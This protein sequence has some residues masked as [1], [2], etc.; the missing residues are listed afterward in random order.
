ME[1]SKSSKRHHYLPRCYLRGFTNS[2]G[3]FYVYD[4]H[5]DKIFLTS[6]DASFFENNLNTI[7]SSGD[8]SKDFLEGLYRD[9]ENEL[10]PAIAYIIKAD[11]AKDVIGLGIREQIFLFLLF[12]HW[13][14][15]SNIAYVQ[16][17]ASNS[18]NENGELNYFTLTDKQGIVASAAEIEK[19]RSSA[20]F[21]KVI[22]V[23]AP[24]AP[25]FHDSSW[26]KKLLNW[27]FLYTGDED[28]WYMVGDNPI[29]TKGFCDSDPVSCLNEFVL[30]VSSKILLVNTPRKPIMKDLDS[31]YTVQFNA[32]MIA[33]A[34]RFVAFQNENFLKEMIK[35]YKIYVQHNMINSVITDMFQMLEE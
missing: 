11:H 13:R 7:Q 3:S 9:M 2:E 21:E 32:A 10:C 25:F 8:E 34:H 23:V 4:K 27:R 30:P 35:Y 16:A 6:P 15:P 20:S 29:I 24:F 26:E 17:L 18:F 31:E 5:A 22:K 12:L 19:I 14:L 1:K 28:N 33:R